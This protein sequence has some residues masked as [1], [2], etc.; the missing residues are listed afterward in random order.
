[1]V[2]LVMHEISDGFESA[3]SFQSRLLC[4]HKVDI[5]IYLATL[6]RAKSAICIVQQEKLK[7]LSC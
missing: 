1:M 4:G 6:K 5:P 2:S 3:F 7:T